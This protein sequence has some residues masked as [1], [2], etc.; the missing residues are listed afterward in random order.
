MNVDYLYIL[1]GTDEYA[2][3]HA[4]HACSLALGNEN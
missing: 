2:Q 1:H 4:Q 3:T